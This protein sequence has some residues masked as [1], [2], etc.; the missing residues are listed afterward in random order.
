MSIVASGM[1]DDSQEPS[2]EKPKIAMV[3]LNIKD[4]SKYEVTG[5]QSFCSRY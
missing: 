2:G 5:T 3:S 4:P 1:K